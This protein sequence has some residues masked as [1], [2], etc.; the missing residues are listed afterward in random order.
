MSQALSILNSPGFS[1]PALDLSSVPDS[2]G[3]EFSNR[4]GEVRLGLDQDVD[5]LSR[6][7]KELGYLGDTYEFSRHG[8]LTVDNRRHKLASDITGAAP[9]RCRAPG[10][11]QN[12]RGGTDHA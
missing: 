2:P 11:G 7:A 9:V 10:P 8:L 5:T 3:G 1:S 12:L 4:L 6:D